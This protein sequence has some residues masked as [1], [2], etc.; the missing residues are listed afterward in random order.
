M[1]RSVYRPLLLGQI[2]LLALRPGYGNEDLEG[3]LYHAPLDSTEKYEALSYVWGSDNRSW[4][5][6]LPDGV[7]P[8]TESLHS[9]LRRLRCPEKRWIW[10]D[11]VRINQD[12]NAEKSQQ[13]RLMQR[14]HSTASLVIVD[15]GEVADDSALAFTVFDA[16]AR[17]DQ[18]CVP[19][20]SQEKM[21]GLEPLD[22]VDHA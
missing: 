10:V 4:S 5:L 11:A 1:S 14:I 2:R 6:K 8:I 22:D 16:L 21:Q 18:S 7:L 17:N 12:D 13:V 20:V 15:L 9:L 19:S 3:E